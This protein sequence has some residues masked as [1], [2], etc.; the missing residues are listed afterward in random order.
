MRDLSDGHQANTLPIQQRE[1]D[2]MIT[3]DYSL[4]APTRYH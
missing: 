4:S 2:A 1:P 3:Y